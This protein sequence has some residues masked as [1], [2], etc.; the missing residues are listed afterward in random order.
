MAGPPNPNH[1]A[2]WPEL[3]RQAEARGRWEERRRM[4][5]V[6]KALAGDVKAGR[7]AHTSMIGLL[8]IVWRRMRL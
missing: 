4:A 8:R 5:E 6:I 2:N 1:P 7:H 3:E